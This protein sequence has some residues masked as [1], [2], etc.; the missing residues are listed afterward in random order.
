[1]RHIFKYLY[2]FSLALFGLNRWQVALWASSWIEASGSVAMQCIGSR[3][4]LCEMILNDHKG[5]EGK[6]HVS[7]Q[8]F[9]NKPDERSNQVL[10]LRLRCRLWRCWTLR[11]ESSKRSIFISNWFTLDFN[12]LTSSCDFSKDAF[13]TLYCEDP[14]RDTQMLKAT[15][16]FWSANKTSSSRSSHV[17]VAKW[18]RTAW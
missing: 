2:P 8:L 16:P 17:S 6:R 15:L 12:L 9:F 5:S 4:W 1:M 7:R 3:W 14:H 10:L 18:S 11:I 13:K